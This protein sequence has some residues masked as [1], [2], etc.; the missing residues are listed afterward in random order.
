[1]DDSVGVNSE[2]VSIVCEVVNGAEG[3]AVDD[4][5]NPLRLGVLDDMG[6]LDELGFAERAD[7]AALPV[8]A[9]DFATESLLM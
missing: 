8:S 5:G 1:M 3:E 9:Q 7:R 2:E 6:R 4:C